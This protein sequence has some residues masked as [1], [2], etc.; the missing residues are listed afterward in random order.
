MPACLRVYG[1]LAN[2]R[3][4]ALV[5]SESLYYILPN[6][7]CIGFLSEWRRRQVVDFRRREP[8]ASSAVERGSREGPR[9]HFLRPRKF[10]GA[11]EQPRTQKVG[12][13]DEFFCHVH[14]L[15]RSFIGPGWGRRAF[16]KD[17]A[18]ARCG[19]GPVGRPE[20][21]VAVR[22]SRPPSLQ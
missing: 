15:S 21:G 13:G 1:V 5:R 6:F 8:V 11:V 4:I 17:G 19:A 10:E 14:H 16:L 7:S 20:L 9:R 3:V 12:Q 18:H 2:L 22:S